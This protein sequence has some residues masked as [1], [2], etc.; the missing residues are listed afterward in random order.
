MAAPAAYSIHALPQ[1]NAR[2]LLGA[3]KP[4]GHGH[5]G[6]VFQTHILSPAEAASAA[7]ADGAPAQ[8]QLSPQ[9]AFK[10]ARPGEKVAVKQIKLA[11]GA[12]K[13]SLHT[14]LSAAPACV[15]SP[16]VAPPRQRQAHMPAVAGC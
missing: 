9:A 8:A 16:L 10:S 3:L 7:A 6:A 1:G 12:T 2:L 15:V 5:H 4:L 14:T 11:G 13:V